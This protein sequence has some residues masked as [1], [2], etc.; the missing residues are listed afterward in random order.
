MKP[1]LDATNPLELN[2]LFLQ[3]TRW[4]GLDC[5]GCY[6]KEHNRGEE[7]FHIAPAVWSQLFKKFYLSKPSEKGLKCWANQ[8]TIAV[9]DLSKSPEHALK[10]TDIFTSII[11]ECLVDQQM[12][13][14]PEVHATFNSVKTMS[15]YGMDDSERMR[16]ILQAFD[17]YSFSHINNEELEVLK[18]AKGE[19]GDKFQVNYNH[20]IPTNVTSLNIDKYIDKM[21]KIGKVVDHIYLVMFKTPVGKERNDLVKIGDKSRMESDIAY[22]N[23]ILE[24]LPGSVRRK[25]SVDG[26][27]QDTIKHT[28]TGFG[29]SSN[30]SRVQVWPD[31]SVSGCPYAFESGR[32]GRTVEDILVNIARARKEYD[33]KDKCHLPEVYDSITG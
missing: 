13:E 8:I 28:K 23:T 25:V 12:E 27:L 5:S 26:C 7:D 21:T 19:L 29:C 9:D 3:P 4:C 31:G 16:A 18:K 10:M 6:V 1:I 32:S 24:R 22:I 17:M 20:L 33:F 14:Y 2:A 15:S 30:V 11:F